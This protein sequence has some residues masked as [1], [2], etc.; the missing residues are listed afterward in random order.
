MTI[1]T[2]SISK[3]R[4]PT[5]VETRTGT[6]AERNNDNDA[7]R[8]RC[9]RRECSAVLRIESVFNRLVR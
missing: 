5:S 9:V 3:P 7:R 2:S 6:T 8:S 1:A 4:A